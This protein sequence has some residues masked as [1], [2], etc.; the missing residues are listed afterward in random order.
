[1]RGAGAIAAICAGIF[2]C[3][4]PAPPT[5]CVSSREC[6]AL[7]FVCDTASSTC[8]EC[9]GMADCLSAD[10]MCVAHRC[11]SAPTCSS[12]RECPGLV[13]D[14]MLGHCVECVTDVDCAAGRCLDHS[15]RAEPDAGPID[16]GAEDVGIDAAAS[17]AGV[18]AVVVGD[19]AGI[20]AGTDAGNDAGSDAGMDAALT[21]RD[22]S[23]DA[24][25]PPPD[26]FVPPPDAFVPPDAYVAPDAFVPP[27]AWAPAP[28]DAALGPDSGDPCTRPPEA[29]GT[30]CAGAVGLGPVA[31]TGATV[32]VS[33]SVPMGS[34]V[35]YWFHA[36][37]S[38]DTACDRLAVQIGFDTNPGSAYQFEVRR[39]TCASGVECGALATT[40]SWAT[41][42]STTMGASVVGQCPC[43][44]TGG[45]STL[46]QCGDESSVFYVGVQRTSGGVTCA[47]FL[48]RIT[49]G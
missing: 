14:R 36:V 31:D 20:D 10:Q 32:L 33:G 25:V 38:P 18:D 6:S 2:G 34:T 21:M 45:T 8:V 17:D 29:P 35:W 7:G 43:S 26:A 46:N 40:Y 39:G 41:N 19:D 15:C 3:S 11:T 12:S 13:C 16:A 47:P 44:P 28:V 1:M 23:A 5:T 37:D 30:S 22:A 48:L 4:S 49:N 27:D 24:F 9:L 42:A